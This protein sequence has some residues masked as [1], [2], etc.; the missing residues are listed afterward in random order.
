MVIKL[1]DASDEISNWESCNLSKEKE[2]EHSAKNINN[3]ANNEA[4][5]NVKKT[6]II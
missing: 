2:E 6:D 4:N 5:E 1:N 3:G